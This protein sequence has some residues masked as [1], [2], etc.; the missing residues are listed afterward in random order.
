[1]NARVLAML[2]QLSL[3]LSCHLSFFVAIKSNSIIFFSPNLGRATIHSEM[4]GRGRRSLHHLLAAG[5]G[6]GDSSVR[7]EQRLRVED[8]H[9]P[10]STGETRAALRRRGPEHVP[11]GRPEMEK[12]LQ[13]H[14]VM[15][16]HVLLLE[17]KENRP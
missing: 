12:I 13:V 2:E 8:S 16:C 7:L 1:M 9:F 15:I 3:F 17:M 14:I 4:G 10:Q 11:E 5:V 6:G